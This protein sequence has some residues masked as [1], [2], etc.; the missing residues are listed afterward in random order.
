MRSSLSSRTIGETL[1]FVNAF[2]LAEGMVFRHVEEVVHDLLRQILV[3][4]V[5]ALVVGA[6]VMVLYMYVYVCVCVC[7]CK[8]MHMQSG[9]SKCNGTTKQNSEVSYWHA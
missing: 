3:G 6:E 2:L 8:R 1:S 4:K 7:V 5:L 9:P